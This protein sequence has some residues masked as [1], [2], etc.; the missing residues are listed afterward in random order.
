ME[1]LACL[2][3]AFLSRPQELQI[4][5][6]A[7]P[8]NGLITADRRAAPGY[9]LF[10]PLRSG[11]I[12]LI[13]ESGKP[14][15]QWNHGLPPITVYLKDNGN[16]LL[17]SRIDENP[18]FF[19][20]GLGGR[21]TEYDW[22]GNLVWEYVLSDEKRSLHHDLEILPN[23]NLLVIA[24]EHLS[25]AEAIA[26]G[27]DPR[28]VDEKGWWPDVILEL[29]LEEKSGASV[30]WEWRARD[31]LVQDFAPTKAN[32]GTVADR[33]ERIDINGDHRDQP[34]LTDAERKQLAEEARKLRELGYAGG[35]EEKH[36]ES[37][38][39]PRERRGDFLH[40]NS[41]HYLPEHD[42]IAL[43][44]PH[45]HELWILDHSTTTAEA[46][47]SKGGRWGKGGD[48]LYRWGN[49]RTYGCGSAANQQLF[50]QHQPDWIPAGF[51]GGGHILVFNNGTR[52][53]E[54]EY[55]SV[56]ELVLPFDPKK[57]F[58]REP[59]KAFEPAAP[60][61][62][63]SA[64]EKTDFFSFFISGAQRLKNG[65]TFICSGKQGRFFEVTKE[66]EIV[67]EYRNPY[68]GE[69]PV[70][71]GNAAPPPKGPS[72]VELTS[73]FRATKLPPDHKGLARLRGA[74]NGEPQVRGEDADKSTGK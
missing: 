48:L 56:D 73:C 64:P 6:A 42:L 33:P 67:W 71:A 70:T 31:H 19:G 38:D 7:P 9:V 5:A 22:D 32:Y 51:P 10:A 43:S 65:N 35:D 2:A 28:Y 23:G 1:I 62:S 18:T 13:D 12:Y 44:T 61:W 68:G 60:T 21:I 52:R 59:G 46:R 27:R 34:P 20:G 54:V 37:G 4:D 8:E 74:A 53:G 49:P 69:L 16:V 14:V 11:T 25:A 40:T 66:G 55:S 63:Y 30:Q 58:R 72:P 57:G 41:I 24:W 17:A 26:L 3:L 29:K 50:F 15:H 47:G 39:A 36:A 45:F